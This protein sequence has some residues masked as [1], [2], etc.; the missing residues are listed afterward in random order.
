MDLNFFKKI[1]ILDGGMGQELLARG[2]VSYGTL[3]SAGALID[4]K[5]HQLLI[6]TH[7]SFIESGADVILTNTFTSRKIRMSQN[8]VDNLFKYANLKACK[9]A[10]K[11]KEISK[12]NIL[13]AGSV[14]AQ[15]NTYEV[16]TR[17]KNIIKENFYDQISII[18]PY[19][20]FFY[21]DVISSGRE[22]EIALDI[23][24]K[25]NKPV[26]IG[27]YIKKNGKLPSGESITEIIKKFKSN[28]WLG[29]ILACVSPEIIQKAINE[30]QKTD[31]PFGF[32]ANLWKSEPLPVHKFNKS[33]FNQIGENPNI[34]MGKREDITGKVFY[35]FVK[36][37]TESG[38][39]ILGGC[40]ETNTSH[41]KE[42][43]KL[44]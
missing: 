16:D 28:N 11:A 37:T 2:L 20:D 15:N 23:I 32:K 10:L 40:C 13:I 5:N 9:L 29:V 7:L 41:I 44:K 26:L 1:R 4:E 25:L 12:K 33:K 21:L 34:I 30:L 6:D 27:L 19:I 39:T 43:S 42:I 8:K 17:D 18:Y 31:L 22:I 35:N 36:K 3:W 24:E 14:P 38:A